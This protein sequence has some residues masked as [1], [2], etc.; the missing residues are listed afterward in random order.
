MNDILAV[1]IELAIMI[2]VILVIRKLF[3]KRCNPNIIYFLWLFVMVRTLIPIHL[4]FEVPLKEQEER[5]TTVFTM[6]K[7]DQTPISNLIEPEKEIS[8]SQIS[9]QGRMVAIPATQADLNPTDT[10]EDLRTQS[11][12][13]P[14]FQLADICKSIWIF[15]CLAF[16]AYFFIVNHLFQKRMLKKRVGETDTGIPIYETD[17]V[18][19]LI[20]LFRPKILIS[21]EVI[22]QPER[23]KYVIMHESEH[24]RAL[25]NLWLLI[26]NICLA[27]QWFN[28]FMWI[29]YFTIAEDCELACDDRV[30]QKLSFQERKQYAELLL[31]LSTQR[32]SVVTASMMAQ[33]GRSTV[34]KRIMSVFTTKKRFRFSWLILVMLAITVIVSVHISAK[35]NLKTASAIQNESIEEPSVEPQTT[36]MQADMY[37][38][39][40]EDASIL[41]SQES[42]ELEACY[43]TEVNRGGGHFWID[44]NGTLWGQGFNQYGELRSFSEWGSRFVDPVKIADDV[45]H[46]D[47]SGE[48]FLIYLTREHKLYGLGGNAAGILDEN[49][50]NDYNCVYMHGISEPVLLMEKVAYARCGYTT[51]LALLQNS[52]VWQLGNDFF[53]PFYEETYVKPRLIMSGARYVAS[54]FHTHAVIDEN[55]ALWTWGSN[56]FGQ[57]GINEACDWVDAPRKVMENV[58][59]AWFGKAGFCDQGAIDRKDILIVRQKEGSIWGCGEGLSREL[60]EIS[61]EEYHEVSLKDISFTWT[62]EDIARFLEGNQIDYYESITYEKGLDLY[63]ANHNKWVFIFNEKGI[64]VQIRSDINDEMMGQV[65]LI[66]GDGLE[67]V[68]QVYGNQYKRTDILENYYEI[69]YDM[70][71]FSFTV[72]LYSDLGGGCLYK[73]R[74]DLKIAE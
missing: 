24:Y 45:I 46:V 30:I 61:L 18:N 34:K 74:E 51:I 40:T 26:K 35:A 60:Q 66:N 16:V 48:Y 73:T 6:T 32:K 13:I 56:E 49:A 31:M 2:L 5:L 42:E 3:W 59:L 52:E 62:K 58:S 15:G 39:Y 47:Y 29:A 38:L 44:E 37:K 8:A 71:D 57:C 41:A 22:G 12:Q 68:V 25:D 36:E 43:C 64:L 50:P 4:T 33:E 19:G 11:K 21:S 69:Q 9:D 7:E 70:G 53:A 23:E 10:A 20:G 54:C 27:L 1:S 67:K 17:H 65:N 63:R 28:P 55:N 72:C 14:R